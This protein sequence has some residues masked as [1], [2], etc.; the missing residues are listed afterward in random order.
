MTK[1]QAQEYLAQVSA[2]PAIG[3]ADPK[4]TMEAIRIVSGDW[5]K[6]P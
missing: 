1:E 3:L 5:G 6:R 2:D 4:K